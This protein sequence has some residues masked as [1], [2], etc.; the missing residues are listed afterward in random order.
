MVP[1]NR[2]IVR[3]IEQLHIRRHISSHLIVDVADQALLPCE[4]DYRSQKTFTHTVR[5]IH[6]LCIAPFGH[7]ITAPHDHTIDSRARASRTDQTTEA[8]L[9]GTE[10]FCPCDSLIFG[11]RILQRGHQAQRFIKRCRIHTHLLRGTVLPFKTIGEIR[12]CRLRERATE[13]CKQGD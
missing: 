10:C 2:L 11:R 7:H 4:S 5:H 6:A 8:R 9:G 3:G 12:W 13:S 1:G